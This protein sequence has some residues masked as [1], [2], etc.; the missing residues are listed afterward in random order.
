MS[1]S[2][3]D[4]TAFAFDAILK[5]NGLPPERAQVRTERK[6]QSTEYEIVGELQAVFAAIETLLIE[7]PSQGYSTT[8]RLIA[9]KDF[10]PQY[11]ALVTRSNSAE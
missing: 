9:M 6:A 11:R 7:W 8:V 2:I 3:A 4:A 10:G 1:K 5:G